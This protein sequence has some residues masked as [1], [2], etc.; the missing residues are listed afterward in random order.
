MSSELIG[1]IPAA[2]LGT[3]MGSLTREVPK[4]LIKVEDRTLLELAIESLKAIGVA[5]I[6]IVTGHFGDLIR[7]SVGFRD[8]G[9]PIEFVHQDRQLGLA[10]AI[11]VARERIDRDFVLLCPDNIYS[12][13][14]DLRQAKD[15]FLKHRPSLLMVATV[16]PTHQ[17]DRSKYFS[18]SLS[19]IDTH[20]YAIRKTDERRG[21]LTMTS[22][23]CTFLS[24]ETLD[25]LPRF[26]DRQGEC[27][28]AEF[29]DKVSESSSSLIYLLRGTRYDLSERRD[30]EDYLELQERLRKTSARGVSAIL[31]D[32]E[33]KVLLQHRD[34]N[35]QIR[36]PGHWALFGGTIETGETPYAAIRREIKEEIGYDV[37]TLSLFLEF[38]Q[39]GKREFAFVGEID[40]DP[41]KL[42]LSEGQGM[43]FVV[44]SKLGNMLIRPDDRATLEAYFGEIDVGERAV[45]S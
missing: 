27:K 17:R 23:G 15:L 39:N 10:H 29:T 44:V 43:D 33:E 24:R 28:F 4:A 6:V 38:V 30:V 3:R 32:R 25:L 18:K 19:A 42:S 13:S 36:Y 2:G 12:D 7:D 8:F 16:N 31:I 5:K 26:E 35:P 9:V 21:G 1:V 22:T 45:Q 34:D 14:D 41:D 37:P 20:L 40:A 11:A